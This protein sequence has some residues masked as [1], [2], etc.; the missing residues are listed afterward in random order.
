MQSANVVAH[1]LLA[2]TEE[3]EEHERVY[4]DDVEADN[5]KCVI[6]RRE[7]LFGELRDDRETGMNCVPVLVFGELQTS[8]IGKGEA[9]LHGYVGQE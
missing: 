8:D 2:Q 3:G 7:C 6:G 1:C 4:G 5:V 9:G